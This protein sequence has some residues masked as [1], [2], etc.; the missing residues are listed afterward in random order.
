MTANKRNAA[1]FI[2]IIQAL[3]GCEPDP[4]DTQINAR[5]RSPDG[6]LEAIYAEDIG[7]GAAVGV[8]EEVFVV[9]P[10]AFPH[11]SERVFSEECAHNIA[12]TWEA[13]RTLRV[14]YDL[15]AGISEAPSLHKPSVFSIFASS[16]W[17]FDHPHEI[18]VHLTRHPTPPKGG[19]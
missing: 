7:G 8:T 14:S 5:V 17:T 15:S 18:Q 19:C 9:T 12:M 2:V 13:P 1:T 6:N 16:Y 4:T 3:C 11:L 10:R